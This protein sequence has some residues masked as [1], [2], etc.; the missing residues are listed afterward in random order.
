MKTIILA[1]AALAMM[2]NSVQGFRAPAGALASRVRASS[3]PNFLM[4]E[5][6]KVPMIKTK[7]GLGRTVDQDGKSNVWAV[8]PKMRVEKNEMS[9]SDP[10]ILAAVVAATLAL[11]AIPLF[12]TLFSSG[13]SY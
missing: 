2:A 8:E 4:A 7:S 9:M 3:R 5:D 6:D 11:V 13:G 12:P 1:F 10:K